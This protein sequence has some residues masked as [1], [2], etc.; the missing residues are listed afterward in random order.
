MNL[1]KLISVCAVWLLL[2]PLTA[3]EQRGTVK[4][5]GLPVPGATVT[6]SNGDRKVVAV[7]DPQGVYSFADLQD[8]AWTMQVDMLCFETLKREMNIGSNSQPEDWELKLLPLDQIKSAAT[9]LKTPAAAPPTDA[10]AKTDTAPSDKPADKPKD[11]AAARNDSPAETNPETAD[12]FLINGSVNNGAASPFA[13]FAAFGNNRRGGRG[14]YNGSIG[15]IFDNS[16]LDARPFSLTGQDTARPSYTHLQG[17]ATF[18]GPLKI[19]HLLKNGPNIFIAYQWVRNRN[20]STQSALMPTLDQRNGDFSEL[21]GQIFDASGAPIPGNMIPADQISKQ[22]RALLNL[23]PAPNF[24]GSSRYNY[25]IP[26][27]GST[28]QDSLQGR[29]N[30]SIGRKNQISGSFGLQSTRSDSPSVFG[31]LDTTDSLGLTANVSWREVF[32]P[33][34]FGNLGYT[35]SRQAA[36]ITPFFE[37]RQNVSGNAGITGNN[38]DAVNWGPPTL[39]FAG[40][41]TSLT[42]ASASLARNQTNSLTYSIFWN[43]GRHNVQAGIDY[44]RQQFN[45]LAQ[46]DARGTFTFTG[47]TTH[48]D[49]AGFLLGVPDTSG[50]AFGNADKYFRATTYNAY[51]NDDWRVSPELTLNVGMRWE[52]GSPITEIYGRLVNLDIASGFTREAP[53]VA[54]KPAGTVTGQQYPDSLIR[55]DKAGFEPRIGLS[56]RP[57]SG[58]S[59]VIRA[60]YGVYYNTSVF[61]NIAMQMAQQAPLSKSLSVQNSAANP[62]TLANGF[63]ASTSITPNT[64]AVDPNFRVGFAHNWQVS[65]QRDLPGALVMTATYLGIK[66]TRG[67]QEFLPNTYPIGTAVNPCPTCPAGYISLASNGN[68]TKESG[69]IQLRRR[70]H[71]GLTATLQYAYSKA[72]DDSALGGRGQANTLI[73]QNWLDLSAERGLSTFD[74]RHLLNIQGQYTTGMGIRGG[75]LV[76]GWRGALMKEW[77]ISSQI[78]VGSGFPLTPTYFAAVQGTGVTGPI[79]PDYTGAPLYAAPSGLFLN[80]A[81]YVAPQG[82]QWGNAGRD[83]II[84]PRQFTLNGSMS[85]TFRMNDRFNLDVRLDATNALNHVTYPNWNTTITSAQ[86]GLPTT[87]N[88]MRSV[89]TSV[90]LRF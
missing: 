55:P 86:F 75:T 23:F 61:Q 25:Q 65:I 51:V 63:N 40:G 71:N 50:I 19:P 15:L 6:A 74:Q 60:G 84:G 77:T 2:F 21:P 48:S 76:N 31:F 54:S 43:R 58:S 22:A 88:P 36:R 47:A 69:Q 1:Q 7:T 67:M 83:S 38:Q 18:G 20:A 28:H 42:D 3:A 39:N 16:A 89:Q 79:R 70:L 80:P 73:A 85:R 90:R 30:K 11:Q 29:F 46:Q 59:M 14:L 53:V 45:T 12:N 87:A 41:I 49:F 64:F 24:S 62:L 56:W 27:I 52:Y 10:Q 57:V 13:Q 35:Y 26:I 44:R 78:T 8:G 34:F 17:V 5:G 37:N 68:S 9:I 4:F 66:G 33:R 32:T 72:I 81:A 82:G